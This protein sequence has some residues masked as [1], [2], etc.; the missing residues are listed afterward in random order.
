MVLKQSLDISCLVTI[1]CSGKWWIKWF[2]DSSSVCVYYFPST[3][4]CFN[5]SASCVL[6]VTVSRNTSTWLQE[7]P[8]RLLYDALCELTGML[9]T[10]WK[11]FLLHMIRAEQC[12]ASV[13]TDSRTR[14]AMQIQ[15]W[16]GL[17]DCELLHIKWNHCT[18]ILF[19]LLSRW[20]QF[21][22]LLLWSLT[23][24]FSFLLCPSGENNTYSNIFV[25]SFVYEDLFSA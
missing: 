9:M 5:F 14:I 17:D 20:E 16:G 25:G 7:E 10:H 11:F 22:W 18:C 4:R 6:L 1:L 23:W 15:T 21:V 19:F 8:S 2:K 13:C 24:I 12:N 3:A